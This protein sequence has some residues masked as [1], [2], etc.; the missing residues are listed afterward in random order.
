VPTR[1]VR[2]RIIAVI[3]PAFLSYIGESYGA[4]IL[5]QESAS[6][7]ERNQHIAALRLQFELTWHD[8][9]KGTPLSETTV[10]AVNQKEIDYFLRL[11]RKLL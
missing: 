5:N 2:P 11:I 8:K 3:E 1:D 9:T 7:D 10:P 6:D 4:I